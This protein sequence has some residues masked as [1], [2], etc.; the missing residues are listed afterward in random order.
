MND[1]PTPETKQ[2]FTDLRAGYHISPATID[3]QEAEDFA[4]KLERERDAVR[5]L[6]TLDTQYLRAERDEAREQNAAL[7]D[8]LRVRIEQDGVDA[9]PCPDCRY[10]PDHAPTCR[11]YQTEREVMQ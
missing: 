6:Y 5:E 9:V 3:L 2:L 8:A 11:H 7:R 1:R 10:W 4:R